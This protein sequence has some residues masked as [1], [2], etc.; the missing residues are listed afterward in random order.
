MT[1]RISIF[2]DNKLTGMSFLKIVDISNSNTSQIKF[3]LLS[4]DCKE[5][6]IKNEMTEDEFEVLT[7][8]K[9][10]NNPTDFYITGDGLQKM[11]S[12]LS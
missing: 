2:T 6:E 8:N 1:Y 11:I 10:W 5:I 4:N 7:N 9:K 3:M 12:A